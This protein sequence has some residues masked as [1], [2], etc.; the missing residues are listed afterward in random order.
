MMQASMMIGKTVTYLND[1]QEEVSAAVNSV[2]FKNGKTF[3]HLDDAANTILS[4][5]QMVKISNKG[6]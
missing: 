2:S 4:S 3:Y 1:K 5:S 6:G